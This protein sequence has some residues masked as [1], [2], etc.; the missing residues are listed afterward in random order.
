[1]KFAK[2]LE[3][4]LVPEWRRQYVNYKMMKKHVK[5]V[6][7]SADRPHSEEDESERPLSP[8]PI[9]TAPPSRHETSSSE[10]AVQQ[11]PRPNSRE[12]DIQMTTPV[13]ALPPVSYSFPS[14]PNSDAE[15]NFFVALDEE[16][17]KVEA[18]YRLREEDAVRRFDVIKQQLSIY[19]YS[20]QRA[21]SDAVSTRSFTSAMRK[22]RASLLELYRYLELIQN[23]RLLNFTAAAKILKKFD[24][25]AGWRSS[26][27][28]LKHVDEMNFRKSHL[29]DQM[30]KEVETWYTEFFAQKQRRNAMK[31]LRV[32]DNKQATHHASLF[33]F[34]FY[35]GMS[36]P[37]LV[38]S[39]VNLYRREVIEDPVFG[40]LL[41]I[42][43]GLSTP[44]IF[45]F[46][47][48]ANLYVWHSKKVNYKFIFE[49]DPRSNLSYLQFFEFSGIMC[50]LFSYAVYLTF[51]DPFWGADEFLKPYYPLIF[52]C[53]IAAVL[54]LPHPYLYWSSRRWMMKT[55]YRIIVSPYYRV[56]FRD[57]FIADEFNS[58]I[59][60][61]SSI[62]LFACVYVHN[63]SDLDQKCQISRSFISPAVN[64]APA[65]FR[66]MQCLRQYHDSPQT[67]R[68]LA[69]AGKYTCIIATAWCSSWFN[70]YP[71]NE[72]LGF[73]IFASTVATF[74]G[75]F[76]DIY[77][78]WGL[79][80]SN[81]KHKYLR[82]EITYPKPF[83]YWAVITNLFCR[84]AWILLVS[85]G[86]WGQSGPRG[87]I[88]YLVAVVELLR[89]FQ[90]NFFRMENEHM[91]N[92]DE[93]RVV[94]DIPLPF[95]EQSDT[96]MMRMEEGY[97][98]DS[99]DDEHPVLRSPRSPR[100]PTR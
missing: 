60:F 69:N 98:S 97:V 46:L 52:F 45:M 96:M 38:A 17:A 92:C 23:Y 78:D 81:P 49:F 67:I 77:H 40:R 24:K 84:G 5:K 39:S 82:E 76:W 74:Y 56:Q 88:V 28:Y 11:H 83:Y 50:F 73:W 36:I 68:H 1:M 53:L 8:T 15:R 42:S 48:A 61:L 22:L 14:G 71:S 93:F 16:M 80:R 29:V 41:Q 10:H 95:S 25:T 51:M 33:R 65:Y 89:R 32:P 59:Y 100:S 37:P 55:V 54:F 94:R 91:T 35:V 72:A 85:V 43:A 79:L 63:L 58:F 64:M 7:A 47:F 12:N 57:F 87:I 99:Q 62:Q 2:Y 19:K 26:E 21:L 66:F 4:E 18:F 70:I 27:I 75:Y 34:G 31:D 30:I 86:F 6:G 3:A 9:G 44:V 90:W 13:P 20:Q